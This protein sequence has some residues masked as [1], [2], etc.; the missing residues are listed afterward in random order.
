VPPAERIATFDNDGTLWSEQPVYV[1]VAFAVDRIRAL[2]PHR[3]DWKD[4]QPFKAVLEGDTRALAA[5]GEHGLQQILA[6]TH[7][8]MTTDEFETIVRDW[9]GRARHPRFRVTPRRSAG[10]ATRRA[11]TSTGTTTRTSTPTAT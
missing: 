1:Q 10:S 3:P 7:A 4:T 2:A 8:G 6:A 5:G 11:R 9:L